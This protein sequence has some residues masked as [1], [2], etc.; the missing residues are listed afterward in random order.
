L[1]RAAADFRPEN[2]I[3]DL[4]QDVGDAIIWHRNKFPLQP[5]KVSCHGF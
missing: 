1:P 4:T 2:E 3:K 5:G